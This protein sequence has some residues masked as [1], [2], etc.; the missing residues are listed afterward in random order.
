MPSANARRYLAPLA[1]FLALSDLASEGM[2]NGGSFR[3]ADHLYKGEP[4]GRLLVGYCLDSVF[5]WMPAAAAF[6]RRYLHARDAIALVIRARAPE[7]PVRVLTVPCGIPR[8]IVEAVDILTREAPIL[9]DRV[10]YV[11]MD[12]DP[13]ALG[14]AQEFAAG[15]PLRAMTFHQGNALKRADYPRGRFHVISSTGLTEFLDDREVEELFGNVYEALEPG[16]TFYTSAS[17]TDPLATRLLDAIDLRARYRSQLEIGSIIG[18]R[19][20]Q[21]VTYVVDPTGLQTFVTAVK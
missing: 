7:G 15:S 4:S 9:L 3:F 16:G 10:E 1:P 5:M 19:P 20:W 12:I 2:A 18:R 11:G 21:H 8:D 13:A 17:A 6:R 14:V